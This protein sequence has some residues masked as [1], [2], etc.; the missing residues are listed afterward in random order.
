M[1]DLDRPRG[2]YRSRG[3]RRS[4]TLGDARH[5]AD[6]GGR[7]RRGKPRTGGHRAGRVRT[8]PDQAENGQVAV[9]MAQ[10]G[11]YD[12][13][14]MDMQMPVMDGFTA[15][16]TLREA[17]FETPIVALTANAMRGFEQEVIGVGCT[18][19][20]TKPVDID[21]LLATVASIIGGHQENA[22]GPAA[23]VRKERCE[24]RT[25]RRFEPDRVAPAG[26][27]RM[28]GVIGRFVERMGRQLP[29]FEAAPQAGRHE[30]LRELAHWLKGAGGTVGFD[31]FTEPAADLEDAARAADTDACSRHVATIVNLA[32]RIVAP[33]EQAPVPTKPAPQATPPGV[34]ATNS[35]AGGVGRRRWPGRFPPGGR[36]T[37]A[38]GDR[39]VRRP[40][41]GPDG[42]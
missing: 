25:R 27:P 34:E 1:L 5:G 7:R 10:S 32:Q 37:A 36:P 21:A 18:A 13:I 15:T 17:G 24:S 14:L 42:R 33:G 3:Q 4:G 39:Q 31:D 26:K 28:H 9:D 29:L 20:L 6:P 8:R 23:G 12:L 16:R 2:Q 38:A 22:A 19:Y 11:S 30:E 41:A 35:D 40:H